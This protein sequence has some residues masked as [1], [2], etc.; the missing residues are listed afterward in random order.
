MTLEQSFFLSILADHINGRSSAALR[1]TL[2]WD[3]LLRLGR[4]HQLEG[5]L[6]HQVRGFLP[7]KYENLFMQRYGA[8]VY[9]YANRSLMAKHLTDEL[10][11]QNIPFFIIKG[12]AVADYYP[13]PAL[14]TMGDTD[15][16][17]HTEDR[18][19][20]H[21]IFLSQ[22]YSNESRI[23][24]RE[25]IYYKNQMEFELHDNLI[26][27]EV[28]NRKEHEEYLKDFWKYVQDGVLDW[29]F[30]LLF[31]L[32]HL[33]KHLMNSGV[34][35]RQFMDVALTAKKNKDLNWAW[36][37]EELDKLGML[38]FA[39]TVFA[40]NRIW[41]DVEPPFQVKEL[42]ASFIEEAT[43][44]VFRNGVFG[45][46]NAENRENAA[47]NIARRGKNAQIAMAFSALR[48][49]FPSYHA[50]CVV[51]HYRFLKG[52]PWLL[53]I[54]WIYRAFRGISRHQ[55]KKHIPFV[56]SSFTSTETIK[57]RSAMLERWGL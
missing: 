41:F 20:V 21:E 31:L 44:L 38:N 12:A 42:Q 33:R 15:L 2:N 30:H 50:L 17:I 9:Y 29:N 36:I 54:A 3:E 8:T 7:P 43:E 25:W 26:Y 32:F 22:G 34:G 45:F 27:S 1:E 4:I 23:E 28:I 57:K 11:A 19:R 10:R 40:L 14:R 48:K 52:K 49:I 56:K 47:V 18:Q 5:V 46:H 13:V 53:P 39:K 37:E 35:F 16:V 55:L 51:E 6:Y 24:D